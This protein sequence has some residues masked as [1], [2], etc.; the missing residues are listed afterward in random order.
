MAGPAS[1]VPSRC[2]TGMLTSPAIAL[3]STLELVT[4]CVLEL[5]S[6]LRVLEVRKELA[7]RSTSLEQQPLL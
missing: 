2:R 4:S 3:H 6:Y 7:A 1:P 5:W